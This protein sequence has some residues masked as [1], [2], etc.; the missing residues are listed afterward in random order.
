LTSAWLALFR[1]PDEFAR[2]RDQPEL[3]PR[4][5]EELL[6]YAGI[7]HTVFR[8][9]VA[10]MDLA[11]VR[12]LA[13]ERVV[14][15]LGS[16]NRDPVQFP[17]PHRLDVTRRP[18]SRIVLG[19]GPHSCLGAALVRFGANIATR[20]LVEKFVLAEMSDAVEWHRDFMVCSPLSLNVLLRR[21]PGG[22]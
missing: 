16:A 9:A 7:V 1:H 3:M 2:L 22:Q 4:A 17:E 13:N 6:R 20:A 12:I 8:Q 14:L 19:A 15:K 10:T 11:G 18:T 21:S 5:I